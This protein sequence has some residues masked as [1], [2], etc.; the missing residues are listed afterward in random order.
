MKVTPVNYVLEFEPI[1][2]NF[3]FSGKETITVNCK[4]LVNSITLHCAEIKIKSCNVRQN[5]IS[6]KAITRTDL[7]K[8]ELTIKIKNKIKGTFFIDIDF[9]GELND[10]LLGF[11]R[12]QYKQNGKTKYLATTQFEAADT[13]RA[14]PCWDEVSQKNIILGKNLKMKFRKAL[15]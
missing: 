15:F 7:K 2:K 11:Y 13:R 5:G 10:R 6:Q 1:F 12:S 8:E 4:A 9:T 14:F 3:T